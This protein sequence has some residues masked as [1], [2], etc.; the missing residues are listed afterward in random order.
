MQLKNGIETKQN[1]TRSNAALANVQDNKHEKFSMKKL[2]WEDRE[3]NHQSNNNNN[4][5]KQRTI[6]TTSRPVLC[7][8]YYIAS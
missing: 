5:N 7:Y 1:S 2:A 6:Y 4:T 8:V 3:Q